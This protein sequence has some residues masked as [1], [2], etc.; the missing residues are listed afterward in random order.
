MSESQTG[1]G[2]LSSFQFVKLSGCQVNSGPL[3]DGCKIMVNYA[4][5][6]GGVGGMIT[7]VILYSVYAV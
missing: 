1:A 3:C 6:N 4:Y 2:N 5:F 7:G